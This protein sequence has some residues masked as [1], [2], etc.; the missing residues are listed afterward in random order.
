MKLAILTADSNGAYPIPAVRGGAV[1]GLV[2]HL[3]KENNRQQVIDMT[4]V[5][6]Y[7]V[8]A[9]KK[10]L[11]YP[12]VSFVWVKVPGLIKKLDSFV[13]FII[14]KF[15][16][17]KKSISFRTIF[18]LLY[19]IIKSS[20]LLKKNDYDKLIL[21]NNVP[22]A[23]IVKFS[24]YKGQV[25]YHFHNLPRTNG[26]CK[27]VF[28][29]CD[30]LCVSNFVAQE[31]QKESSPIYITKNE[32]VHVLKNCVDVNLFHVMNVDTMKMKQ[33]FGLRDADKII[34]YVGRIS[35][36]KGI[37]KLL[38]SL[39]FVTYSNYK[40]LIVGSL[41]YGLAAKDQYQQNIESYSKKFSDKIIYTGFIPQNELPELYNIAD[42]AVLPSVWQEPAGLTMVEAMACGLP[43]ITTQRGGIPEYVADCGFVLPVDENLPKN[44]AEKIDLLF[45][46]TELGTSLSEKAIKRVHENFTAEKY[47]EKFCDIIKL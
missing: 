9:E 11:K 28:D 13:F 14:R 7:D 40:V 24:K 32:T 34:L 15:F 35:A 31:I 46:D 38:E 39:S 30:Y 17:K 41:I 6:F 10:S 16:K 26:F 44:I 25:F 45:S 33:R 12:N 36:E 19:Y 37:D 21:E 4:I 18:S 23:W 42:V 2:E 47:F 8:D 27:S 3:I 20:S 1:Q 5:S 43:V 22:L 29:S